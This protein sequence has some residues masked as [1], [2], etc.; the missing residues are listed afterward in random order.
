MEKSA[1]L[2]VLHLL[3]HTLNNCGQEAYLVHVQGSG[4]NGQFIFSSLETNPQFR[5]PV[6][7]EEI[8]SKHKY[9]G[10]RPIVVYPEVIDGNPLHAEHVVRYILNKPG[11]MQGNVKY[12]ETEQFFLYDIAFEIPGVDSRNLLTLPSVDDRI[13]KQTEGKTF[14]ERELVLVYTGRFKE[15]K[16]HYPEIYDIAVE[17]THD[18]PESKEE[19]ARLFNMAKVVFVFGFTAIDAE[20]RL[21]G[22]VVVRLASPYFPDY[23][24]NISKMEIGI[25]YGWDEILLEEAINSV[26]KIRNQYQQSKMEYFKQLKKFINITQNRY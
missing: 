11:V 2:K 22:C 20:A 19:L 9:D 18:W 6:L 13:F 1:G 21:C 12:T 3:C 7:N 17:I 16:E 4:V 10:L 26:H 15:A 5:T 8:Y 25:S 24:K 23:N 14:D